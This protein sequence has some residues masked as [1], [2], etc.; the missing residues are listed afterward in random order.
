MARKISPYNEYILTTQVVSKNKE[1]IK[2]DGK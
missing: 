2:I 1:N